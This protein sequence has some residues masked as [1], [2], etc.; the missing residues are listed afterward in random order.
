MN[1]GKIIELDQSNLNSSISHSPAINSETG[2][3]NRSYLFSN[4]NKEQTELKNIPF[5]INND[6]TESIPYENI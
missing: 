6:S 1:N 4:T 3:F 5:L 2:A